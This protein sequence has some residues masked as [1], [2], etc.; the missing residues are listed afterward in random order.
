MHTLVVHRIDLGARAPTTFVDEIQ[1]SA[2]MGKSGEQGET[3][4]YVLGVIRL[5]G[6]GGRGRGGGGGWDSIYKTA[7]DAGPYVVGNKTL[8]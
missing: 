4:Y 5:G 8:A 7:L 2:P 3:R 6:G 1:I